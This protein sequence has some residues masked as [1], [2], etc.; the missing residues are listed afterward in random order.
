[1]TK[2][3]QIS[4]CNSE[5]LELTHNQHHLHNPENHFVFLFTD[6]DGNIYYGIC[7]HKVELIEVDS[8]EIS[9]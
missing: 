7:I 3:V 4:K 8:L 9:L 6:N 2:P 5:L 1:M